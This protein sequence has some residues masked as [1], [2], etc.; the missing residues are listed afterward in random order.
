M[1]TVFAFDT[2][3]LGDEERAPDASPRSLRGTSVGLFATTPL[4]AMSGSTGG[5]RMVSVKLFWC[6]EVSS[7]CGGVIANSGGGRFCVKAVCDVKS[8][9]S[10]K[11]LMISNHLYIRVKRKDQ[12][13]IEP[14]LNIPLLADD[15]DPN[16]LEEA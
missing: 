16:R 15:V 7:V 11:V 2:L 4:L 10:I 5:D 12:A 6:K 3:S 8:H 14:A 13:I 1:N 9:L